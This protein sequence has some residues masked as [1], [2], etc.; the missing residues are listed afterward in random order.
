M[1]VL[2]VWLTKNYTDISVYLYG[3]ISVVTT[4]IVGYLMS[5]FSPQSKDIEGL[6]YL[7]LKNKQTED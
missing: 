3:A 7:K 6:T 2:A 1:G 4:I 5:F